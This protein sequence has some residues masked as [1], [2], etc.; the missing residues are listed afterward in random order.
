MRTKIILITGAMFFCRALFA[1]ANYG[2]ENPNAKHPTLGV[3]LTTSE[4]DYDVDSSEVDI[5]RT[6]MF[7][8]YNF[9]LQQKVVAHARFGL[10]FDS[11]LQ[12]RFGRVEND[13]LGFN[14]GGAVEMLVRD[15]EMFD[16]VAGGLISY[17][18]E[19][20]DAGGSFSEEID[21]DL[22]EIGFY[23]K[24]RIKRFD[25][26]YPWAGIEIY[27][28]SNGEFSLGSAEEDIER[29][30]LLT[31]AIGVTGELDDFDL[32]VSFKILS[33]RSVNFV[34]SFPM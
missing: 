32:G 16:I 24:V 26:V 9:A 8:A 6:E 1:N 15:K 3:G 17:Y 2:T 28:Y 34:A 27:P 10:V 21:L 19:S 22:L 23:S 7:A 11:E 25:K 5:E 18:R 20:Y 4:I 31:M 13:G 14:F 30:D 12:N 33:E 29:D